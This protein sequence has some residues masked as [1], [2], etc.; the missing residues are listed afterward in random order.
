M[1]P[2]GPERL[3]EVLS[4]LFAARG[5]GRQQERLRLE[6]AWTEAAGVEYASVTRVSGF[7]RNV[8]EVEVKGA[9]PM[10]ELSQF[11]KKKVLEKLRKQL[12]GMTIA[13][14]RFRAGTW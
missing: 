4:R 14:L 9:V 1:E 2:K 8:L 7:R 6:R 3:S 12:T 10:Q 13:D 11:H 5:W